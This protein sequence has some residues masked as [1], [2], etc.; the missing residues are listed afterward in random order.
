MNH[1]EIVAHR[2]VTDHAPENTMQSFERA[3]ELG[4]DAIE[5]DVRLTKDQVPVVY[6]YFYL[7][8]ITAL[9]GPIFNY[10]YR[11]LRQA[12]FKS[13]PDWPGKGFRI[14][15]LQQVIDVVGGRVGMEIEIKGPEPEAPMLIGEVL[16][17]HRG[18]WNTLEVTSFEPQLLILVQEQCPGITADLLY[19]RSEPWMGLDVVAYSATQMAR[20][21]QARA[22]HLHPTQ[23]SADVVDTVRQAG[24]EVHAWDTNDEYS[25]ELAS[26]LQI[27]VICT[28][29]V[30][31][32][33]NFRHRVKI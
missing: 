31:M 14:P 10:T 11:Q 29:R 22:V 2:G 19:P 28:D 21:A 33:M 25:L 8:E 5:F 3:I 27:P 9:T 1:F 13:L 26:K 15:T 18:L 16:N 32:A 12:Q 7:D 23:L 24:F 30:E 20:R 4:A 17:R 6:H